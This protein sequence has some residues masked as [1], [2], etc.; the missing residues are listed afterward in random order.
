MVRGVDRTVCG[1][2]YHVEKNTLTARAGD[3]HLGFKV[4]V[5]KGP[6]LWERILRLFGYKPKISEFAGFKVRNKA[7][8][9]SLETCP[10]KKYL[11][12]AEIKAMPLPRRAAY[13]VYL[14][15]LEAEIKDIKKA[16]EE[17]DPRV[18]T[19]EQR[20]KMEAFNQ[21]I[22]ELRTLR[23][24]AS[25]LGP[26]VAQMLN[27]EIDHLMKLKDDKD[28]LGAELKRRLGS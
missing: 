2:T 9:S 19:A 12:E 1:I 3:R 4:K 6:K 18:Q 25:N 11:S 24:S 14:M 7:L 20:G 13:G 5:V 8:K 10:M 16:L 15:A 17:V 28:P 23:E 21:R 22:A 27:R 26:K